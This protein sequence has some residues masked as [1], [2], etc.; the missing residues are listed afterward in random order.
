MGMCCVRRDEVAPPYKHVSARCGLQ[1]CGLMENGEGRFFFVRDCRKSEQT[2]GCPAC[3]DCNAVHAHY[4]R[5]RSWMSAN[6][7]KRS[8]LHRPC[9]Q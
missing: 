3:S 4:A 1:T 6:W 8:N 7:Q 9:W 2:P 5:K